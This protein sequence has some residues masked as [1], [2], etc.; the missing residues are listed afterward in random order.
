MVVAVQ[1]HAGDEEDFDNFYRQEHM[2]QVS[3]QPGWRRSSRYELAKQIAAP[4]GSDGVK[5]PFY[6]ALH[7]FE[8]SVL[9]GGDKVVPF[10]PVSEWTMRVMGGAERIDAAKFRLVGSWGEQASSL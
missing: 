4:A 9:P 7:E 8:D 1:P 5:S 6:L 3:E 10:Q 2:R